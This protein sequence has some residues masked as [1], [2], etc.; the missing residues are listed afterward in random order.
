MAA[1][2][3]RVLSALTRRLPEITWETVVADTPA[4]LA[5]SAIDVIVVLSAKRF[6]CF[7]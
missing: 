3:D 4:A 5:T 6:A 1:C 2:T 7:H